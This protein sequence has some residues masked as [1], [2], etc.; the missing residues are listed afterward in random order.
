M[1]LSNLARLL[2][3]LGAALIVVG[4]VLLLFSRLNLPLGRLP[5]DIHMAREHFS[6][7]VPLGTSLLFSI[8]LTLILNLIIR[9]MNR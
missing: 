8:L 2:I 7:F 4:G 1:E 3:L 9:W 5:G 6:C